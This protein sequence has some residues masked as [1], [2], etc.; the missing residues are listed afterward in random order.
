[1]QSHDQPVL[2]SGTPVRA[3]SR[4][5]LE[6]ISRLAEIADYSYAFAIRAVAS[7][8][9]ADH[10]ADGP[11]HINDLASITE[12]DPHGLLR[13]MRALATKAIFLEAPV[14]MFALSPLAE[15]LRTD[16]PLS[17]RY[18]FRL[19]PDAQALSGLEYSVRTGKPSFNHTFGMG[20]FDWLDAHSPERNNFRESQRALNRLEILA[21]VR[22]RSWQEIDSVVDIGG[23]DGSL[24]SALLERFSSMIGTVFDLPKTAVFAEESFRNAGLTDR[25]SVIRGNIFEGNV[26]RDSRIYIM[27]RILVGF[28]DDEAVVALSR[29]REVM[30]PRSRLLIMEPMAGAA[31]QVGVSLDIL[32]LVLGLGRTRSPEE[33]ERLL[34]KA[35]MKLIGH[36]SLGLVTVLEAGL[37]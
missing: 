14:E 31:D 23:N 18:F 5:N 37:V 33:F 36:S 27:K 9:V 12:C 10:L 19:E 17:M 15:L 28:S 21:I 29:V 20:Y 11:R 16:H 32:M 8:G 22:S 34:Q 13:L 2:K 3:R 26:P 30:S 24:V 4:L 6:G 7:I 25:A 1:M 35:G